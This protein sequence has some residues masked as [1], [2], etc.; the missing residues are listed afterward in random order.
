MESRR[1]TRAETAAPDARAVRILNAEPL[2]Y[3]AEA[4]S[5]LECWATVVEE[6]LSRA[7]LL[8]GV[9]DYDV[10]IVRLAHQVD[11]E[12]IDAGR[13]LKAIVT[14]TTGL[15]HIDVN[16]ARSR[17]I[18]VLSLRGESEFL[19][20]VSATAEHTW[21]LL[22]ALLRRIGPAYA[23]V[24]RGQ[25]DRD[26]FWG[27]E[28]DGRRLGLVGLGRVGQKVA[29]YGLTFGMEAAAYDPHA[30][31]WL[32]GVSRCPTLR[33]L[34]GR[35]DVLSLHVPLTEETE[36]MIGVQEL[37]LLPRSAVVVNTSRGQVLDEEALVRALHGGDLA[38]AALDVVWEERAPGRR[39]ESPLLTYAGV[40]DNVLITPH[41]GGATYE[42]VA[43][44]EVFMAQKLARFFERQEP[45]EAGPMDHG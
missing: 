9:S 24:R 34:M 35:S 22:L 44:T 32:N 37:S 45:G 4:R 19:R 2:R 18:E 21:A 11:R 40:H 29:R 31:G 12:V 43:K 15:D 36:G 20:T 7:D 3:S 27:H 14:A 38:G 1:S 8:N 42:S 13:R 26:L 16:Y 25:W 5:I 39:R 10:L 23:S 28:L 33:D 30:T 6:E 41:I 17:G